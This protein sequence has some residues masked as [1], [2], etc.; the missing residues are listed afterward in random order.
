MCRR[1]RVSTRT[2]NREYLCLS[3]PEPSGSYTAHR[4]LRS[5]NRGATGS[6]DPQGCLG[7]VSV[8]ESDVDDGTDRI[9]SV[10]TI[11]RQAATLVQRGD[12]AREGGIERMLHGDEADPEVGVVSLAETWC[13]RTDGSYPDAEIGISPSGR[14]VVVAL[15][16]RRVGADERGRERGGE[17]PS[18]AV[19][20]PITVPDGGTDSLEPRVV[21]TGPGTPGRERAALERGDGRSRRRRTRGRRRVA[22]GRALRSATS[23]ARR[24]DTLV[25]D[26][27]CRGRTPRVAR[28]R[29]GASDSPD[30]RNIRLRTT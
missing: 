27:R 13:E 16:A 19:V 8:R 5:S 2:Q 15:P 1:P 9:D 4:N 26:G 20:E 25:R 3:R 30:D 14:R 6:I 12:R 29:A 7:S 24:G 10:G 18:G 28:V 17:R 11:R 22:R 23:L 21:D